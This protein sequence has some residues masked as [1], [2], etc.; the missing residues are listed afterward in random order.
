MLYRLS[1]LEREPLA[2]TDIVDAAH[3]HML[4]EQWRTAAADALL[5]AIAASPDWTLPLIEHIGKNDPSVKVL[6]SSIDGSL[7]AVMPL[8]LD[9]RRWMARVPL[10]KSWSHHFSFSGIPLLPAFQADEVLAS[11]FRK[12]N[13]TVGVRA[14]LLERVPCDGPFF[15][16]VTSAAPNGVAVLDPFERAALKTGI[17]YEDWATKSLSSKKRKEYR[18][19]LKRLGETG[20][21]ALVSRQS[22][23]Q[24]APWIEEFLTLEKAGWKGK[25]CTALG[26]MQNWDA[27]LHA[28][29]TN[30]DRTGSLRFWKIT[31]DGTTIA[32]VF[33]MI[34]GR[35][36]W[37]GKMAYDEALSRFSP[38]VQVILHATRDLLCETE[39]DLVDSSAIPG[40][41]MI[42]HIWRDRIELA[43]LLIA[44]PDTS[45]A[46]FRVMV[47]AER[48]RRATASRART[49]YRKVTGRKNS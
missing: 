3:I 29:L 2:I 34:E 49:I 18:R 44:T 41:P 40:H 46:Q 4:A 30:L 42:D 33:A 19:Q 24:L 10:L 26:S 31:L 27:F 38:G 14:I 48:L 6:T 25:Q 9:Q 17:A 35:Q 13:D 16:A 12:A 36:A 28:A 23:D 11:I 22:G 1:D 15:E 37:L 47:A 21:L 45:P 39:I 5:P 43:D 8:Q 7:S 20:K 32:S